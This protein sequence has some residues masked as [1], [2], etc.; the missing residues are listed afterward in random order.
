MKTIDVLIESA[1]VSLEQLAEAADLP[2]ERVEAVFDGRWLPRP[3]ERAALAA[4]LGVEVDAISWGHTMNPRNV[5]YHRFGL[6]EDF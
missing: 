2:I 5:R 6:S 3:T 4:A 1:G